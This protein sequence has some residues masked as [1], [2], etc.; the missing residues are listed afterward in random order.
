MNAYETAIHEN[1]FTVVDGV[2]YAIYDQ[3][4]LNNGKNG[5]AYKAT[6]FIESAMDENGNFDPM[7]DSGVSLEWDC[8]EWHKSESDE[9]FD[10]DWENDATI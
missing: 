10:C 9:E 8:S 1:G 3:P 2:T 4:Y 5:A 6:G 7:F